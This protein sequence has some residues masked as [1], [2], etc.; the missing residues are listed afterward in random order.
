VEILVGKD[1][2]V[3]DEEFQVVRFVVIDTPKPRLERLQ[4]C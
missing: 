3:A 1:K 4:D 2:A